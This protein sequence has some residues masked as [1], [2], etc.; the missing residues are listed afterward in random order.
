MEKLLD[1]S[2]P[3]DVALLDQAVDEFF[4]GRAR[5]EIQEVLVK[6]Q[7]HPDS[8]LR[9][10]TILE[11]SSSPNTKVLALNILESTIKTRWRVLPLEQREGVKKF[12]IDKIIQMSSNPETLKQMSVLI[13][14]MNMILVQ[15]VKRDWPKD[16][17]SFI[18]DLVNSSKQ[19]ES[20]CANNMEILKLLR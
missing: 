15:V 11:Q 7:E 19:S 4:G 10:D 3:L 16:W 18:P 2:Q 17:P 6:L 8:W 20:L 14:K 13:R 9:V 5:K 12:I 1:F